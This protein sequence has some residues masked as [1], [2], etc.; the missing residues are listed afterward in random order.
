M[1]L[2]RLVLLVWL[3]CAWWRLQHPI[4]ASAALL[5]FSYCANRF[6]F[7]FSLLFPLF[8]QAGSPALHL[9]EFLMCFSLLAIL[10][11]LC[12]DVG[13]QQRELSSLNSSSSSRLHA[14]PLLLSRNRNRIHITLHY[15]F[16]RAWEWTQK[17]KANWKIISA[18]PPHSLFTLSTFSSRS[19]ALPTL[20]R[21]ASFIAI[22]YSLL[23]RSRLHTFTRGFVCVHRSKLHHV[24]GEQ[25]MKLNQSLYQS[26]IFVGA[27]LCSSS[28][29]LI[30]LLML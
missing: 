25:K 26:A 3:F 16:E 1:F 7:F 27:P 30:F 10:F 21:C 15:R 2:S 12:E 8:L 28:K 9:I 19:S 17:L 4:A 6:F 29:P 14:V 22:N 24:N 5:T 23:V 20:L 11:F 18:P 13:F